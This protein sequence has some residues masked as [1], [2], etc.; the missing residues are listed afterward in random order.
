MHRAVSRID[1]L[2]AWA[3]VAIG[4]ALFGAARAGRLFSLL[5]RNPGGMELFGIVT[6]GVFLL[7]VIFAV[8]RRQ[9]RAWRSAVHVLGTLVAGN[10]FG[11][12]LIWPFVPG[13][14]GLSLAPMLRDTMLGGL[15][16]MALALPLCILLLWASRKYGS[17][18]S[19]TERRFRVI[20]E[21][22]ARRYGPG[23]GG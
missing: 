17:H 23:R 19:L 4:V 11:L 7:L 20:R 9:V 10:A 5:H 16:M 18:S 14:Y 21:K 15:S 1:Q 22:L 12:V 8:R 13:G 6:M 3:F 2:P